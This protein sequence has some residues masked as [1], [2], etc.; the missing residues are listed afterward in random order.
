M[1]AQ[2]PHGARRWRPV[3]VPLVIAGLCLAVALE[4]CC[5]LGSRAWTRWHN[6][7]PGINALAP[8][9]PAEIDAQPADYATLA[10]IELPANAAFKLRVIGNP[11]AAW[12]PDCQRSYARNPWDLAAFRGRLYVG[13]GDAGNQGPSANAGP[14]P[15]YAYDPIADRF[16]QET[17]LPEEQLDR[18]YRHDDQLWIPGDDPRQSW[19]WGNLYQRSAS[20]DW[21]QLRT[22]PNTIHAHPLT[23]QQDRL[24]AGVSVTKAVPKG[25]GTQHFGS[26]VAVSA[27]G[28]EHWDLIRLGGW[29]IFDFLTVQGRLYAT[30]IFPGPGIQRWLDREQRQDFHAPVYEFDGSAAFQRRADLTAAQ[31]F[32]DTPEAGIRAAL[33][34]GALPW[35]DAT[36]YL[37]LT[38]RAEDGA[39]IRGAYLVR[40]LTPGAIDVARLPLPDNVLAMDVRVDDGAL[41]ILFAQPQDDQRWQSTLWTSRDARTW[42]QVLSFSATAPAR[43]FESLDGD[44]YFGLGNLTPPAPGDCTQA[45]TATGTLL[46]LSP[47]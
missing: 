44:W 13:L 47:I 11:A 1:L 16:R 20:G 30:D 15:V 29:R 34:Q 18:F 27:D 33:I 37:G 38:S 39:P 17:T 23:W 31:L 4:L 25:V 36:L 46:A 22:L 5:D 12:Y 40:D 43:A 21:R 3:L 26:A 32:P 2:N 24:F 41:Q 7:W 10:G 8:A 45:D 35:Q 19:D 9:D 6:L 42:R 14:V 28:G